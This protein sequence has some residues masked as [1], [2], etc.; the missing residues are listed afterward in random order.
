MFGVVLRPRGRETQI[1][2]PREDTTHVDMITRVSM[3]KRRDYKVVK[4]ACIV[5]IDF[6]NKGNR[7][8]GGTQVN[9][10]RHCSI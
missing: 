8:A 7:L 1:I 6:Y 4:S 9:M 2:I 3:L 10:A 5:Y